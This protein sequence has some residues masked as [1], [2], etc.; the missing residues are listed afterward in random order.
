MKTGCVIFA[1]NNGLV[2]Y[3]RLAEFAAVRVQRFLD[4]PV[5]LVTDSPE[6]L[7]NRHP[8]NQV[9]ET[10]QDQVAGYKTVHDGN[11]LHTQVSWKNF[12]RNQAFTL[13][14]YD[15]TLVIDSDYMINSSVL[16]PA[17]DRPYDFQIYKNS[18]DL[19]NTR[20]TT[21]FTRISQHSIPFYWATTFIF[22]KNEV[23]KTFFELVEYVKANWFYFRQLYKIKAQRYRNDF[24]FSIAIH[25][26]NGKTKGDFAMELPGIMTYTLDKD[27]LV[28][29][30]DTAMQF[31]IQDQRISTD[32]IAAK[33]QG[34]DVH[35]M[36]K[37]SLLRVLEN[38]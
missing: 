1:H 35:V 30:N 16:K 34:I 11:E 14:P 26:M 3:V 36:N 20:T 12:S 2:D 6:A 32:Y 29:Y 28:D 10:S 17:F 31:L 24:S 33:T 25:L 8:F 23:T 18:F 4:I 21:E 9:I 5:T 37:L 7:S 22:E 15:K 27:L 13:S 19:S 38:V